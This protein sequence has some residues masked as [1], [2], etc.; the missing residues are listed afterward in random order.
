MVGISRTARIFYVSII[1]D[2]RLTLM[3]FLCSYHDYTVRCAC[4]IQCCSGSVFQYVYTF[5]I[6]W[7]D[8][9]NSVTYVVDIVGVVQLFRSNVYRVRQRKTIKYPQ[10]LTVTYDGRSTTNTQTCGRTSFARVLNEKQVGDVAFKCLVY[11]GHV[12]HQHIIHFY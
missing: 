2:G 1:A 11:S 8:T 12:R 10:R 4:A 7:V 9:R 5:N 6:L 3:A